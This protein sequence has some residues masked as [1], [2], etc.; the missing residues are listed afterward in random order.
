VIGVNQDPLGKQGTRLVG[1]NLMESL[2]ATDG[3]HIART[4]PAKV[5]ACNP[6][7]PTQKWAINTPSSGYFKNPSTDLCLNVDDCGSDLIFFDCVTKGG[8][9]CGADCYEVMEF[10]ISAAGQLT[11]PVHPGQCGQLVGSSISFGPCTVSDKWAF[12]STTGA[13]SVT[14]GATTSCLSASASPDV[15]SAT[16]VWGRPLSTGDWAAVFL[17]VGATV[18]DV[19]CDLDCLALMGF[20]PSDQIT[21]IDLWDMDPNRKPIAVTGNFTVQAL[22]ADGGS[23]MFTFQKV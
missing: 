9:C 21:A 2:H 15:N 20:K 12:D 19:T 18:T 16:N 7:D 23:A 14:V 6:K 4:T 3:T 22:A 5:E 10:N 17:N 13:I 11:T 1:N 8:T